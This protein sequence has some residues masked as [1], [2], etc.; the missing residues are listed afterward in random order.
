LE[1]HPQKPFYPIDPANALF[2]HSDMQDLKTALLI[3]KIFED[4]GAQ[5]VCDATSNPLLMVLKKKDSFAS[6]AIKG[7]YSHSALRMKLYTPKWLYDFL[8]APGL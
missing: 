4:N 6:Q 2:A 8:W 1:L 7:I 5:P 3:D